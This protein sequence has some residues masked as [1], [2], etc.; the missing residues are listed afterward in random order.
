MS[1]NQQLLVVK[2]VDMCGRN[3]YYSFELCSREKAE[4]ASCIATGLV[5]AGLATLVEP[6]NG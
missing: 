3:S 5:E 1:S 4:V 6:A 2:N